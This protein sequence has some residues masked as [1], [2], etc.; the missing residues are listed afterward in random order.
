MKLRALQAPKSVGVTA[1]VR[2]GLDGPPQLVT[3]RPPPTADVRRCYRNVR[4]Q[5]AAMGGEAVFGWSV[6]HFPGILIVCNHH[7]VWRQ[8]DGRLLDVTPQKGGEREIT[9]LP[10]PTRPYFGTAYRSVLIGI[11]DRPE[12]CDYVAAHV[13]P[14][15]TFTD[16]LGSEQ[17]IVP[18]EVQ[19]RFSRFVIANWNAHAPCL[20]GKPRKFRN[21]CA[22]VAAIWL[23]SPYGRCENVPTHCIGSEGQP[24]VQPNLWAPSASS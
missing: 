17:P 15:A 16:E 2:L 18:D 1:A 22:S 13:E 24:S 11:E 8:P 5:V 7:A 23:K 9:F 3:S 12:V 14:A 21:C 4:E 6:W 19:R 10:D 20:C